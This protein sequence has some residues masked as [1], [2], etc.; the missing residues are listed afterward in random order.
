MKKRTQEPLQTSINRG[1]HPRKKRILRNTKFSSRQ[2][3]QVRKLSQKLSSL[4][5]LCLKFC[6]IQPKHPTK[7]LQQH[8][9]DKSKVFFKV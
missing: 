4:I 3:L 8:F 9:G 2:V 7:I 1:S 6:W 5:H